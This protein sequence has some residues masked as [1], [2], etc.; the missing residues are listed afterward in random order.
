MNYIFTMLLIGFTILVH[1]FGHFIF[2]KFINMPIK[3]FSIGFGPKIY[4]KKI[5]ATEY[6]L[7]LIPLGGY[8]LPEI[9]DEEEFFKLPVYKRVIMTLGGPI[10]SILLPMICFSIV[11]L[12][13]LDFSLNTI[14]IKP[15]IQVYNLF[16]N[17]AIALPSIFSNSTQVSGFI[18]I[19]AQG[20]KIIDKNI[21]Y[22][23]N[24]M[25]LISINFALLNLLPLPVLD[26]GKIL[27]FLLEKVH[28]KF[29]RLH[30]PLAIAG[31]ILIIGFMVYVTIL[32]VY[33][34][35]V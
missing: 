23:L 10:A 20:G 12:F 24:F 14:I 7:S 22:S 8:V 33:R 9:E 28:C 17:I 4:S 27:L 18:G 32:D 25:G 34:Y 15:I 29:K 31:W 30:Y 16:I 13:L 19:V 5:G 26:G 6:R 1:E 2:A 21:I 11:N 35:I 3:I